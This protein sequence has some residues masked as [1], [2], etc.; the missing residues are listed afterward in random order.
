LVTHA[1]S[2]KVEESQM[3]LQ[4]KSDEA[5][6]W[7]PVGKTIGKTIGKWDF[8]GFIADLWS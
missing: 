3:A 2:R 1:L 7:P 6:F 4:A 8:M 5:G